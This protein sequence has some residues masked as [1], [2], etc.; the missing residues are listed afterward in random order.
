MGVPACY[1]CFATWQ[2]FGRQ[3]ERGLADL[4]ISWTSKAWTAIMLPKSGPDRTRQEISG[5]AACRCSIQRA[6][7]NI[8]LQGSFCAK[9]SGYTQSDND[10]SDG[11][12]MCYGPQ[13]AARAGQLVIP[14]QGM[15]QCCELLAQHFSLQG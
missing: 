6:G 1:R 4:D 14:K 13:A 11:K 9:G 8:G 12:S 2:V 3:N 7:R 5:V 15:F 10:Q